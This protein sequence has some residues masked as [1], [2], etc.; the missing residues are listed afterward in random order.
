MKKWTKILLII[1]LVGVLASTGSYY[2][3]SKFH[4]GECVEGLDGYIWH[5]NRYGLGEYQV[6]GWQKPWWGNEVS[7][8]RGVLERKNASDV[9]SYHRVDCPT[10]GS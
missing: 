7:L 3:G 1:V 4:S 6:M 9:P 2:L 10:L 8:E 5:I